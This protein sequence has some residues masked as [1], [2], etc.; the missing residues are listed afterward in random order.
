[1]NNPMEFFRKGAEKRKADSL[2]GKSMYQPGG[3]RPLTESDAIVEKMQML[4]G[5]G[6]L[7]NQNFFPN[8]AP[9]GSFPPGTAIPRLEDLPHNVLTKE[10]IPP[11]AFQPATLPKV[12][13]HGRPL[14]GRSMVRHAMMNKLKGIKNP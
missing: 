5:M 14:K 7:G 3:E 6:L 9:K 10:D 12:D 1:M 4:D 11:H 2:S 8:A 13:Q